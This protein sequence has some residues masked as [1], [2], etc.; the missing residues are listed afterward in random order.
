VPVPGRR[1]FS[2]FFLFLWARGRGRALGGPLAGR[3][4]EE[5][6]GLPWDMAWWLIGLVVTC[7]CTLHSHSAL[8]IKHYALLVIANAGLIIIAQITHCCKLHALYIAH[9]TLH[10]RTAPLAL[11]LVLLHCLPLQATCVLLVATW[12]H[13]HCLLEHIALPITAACCS[14]W[15]VVCGLV[16]SR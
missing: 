11:V 8:S 15:Y 2:F 16:A 4:T 9:C 5:R 3:F 13:C 6:G 7:C 1:P 10:L 12:C 14:T